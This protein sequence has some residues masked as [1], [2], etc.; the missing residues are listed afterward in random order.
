M[1]SSH[2]LSSFLFAALVPCAALACGSSSNNTEQDLGDVTTGG[3][4]FHV[5]QE[6]V[7]K[8]STTTKYAIQPSGTTAKPDS[9][10]CWYGAENAEASTHVTAS[11]DAND[12]DFDCLVPA[13]A[14]LAADDKL[15]L[16]FTYG[17]QS[18]KGNVAT[19]P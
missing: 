13:P 6:G 17:T 11:Y 15:W 19:K 12:K 16:T 3:Y 18:F 8:A 10:A 2:T 4:T 9:V 5:L 1:H 14:T 7:F